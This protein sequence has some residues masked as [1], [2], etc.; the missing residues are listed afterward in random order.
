MAGL[1]QEQTEQIR[2]MSEWVRKK[3]AAEGTGHDW[4]HIERVR[5]ISL[6]IAKEEGADLFVTEA[7]TLL[8]DMIDVKLDD[9]HRVPLDELKRRLSEDWKVDPGTI[10]G[11][12]AI[13]TRM[14][15]RDREKYKDERLSKE[16][17]AVQDADRLDAIGAVGIARALMYAGAKGHLLY[18]SANAP[19]AVGHFY[20]KLLLLKDL[21]NTKTGRMLAEK[22]HQLML[23][24]L[25]ELE[26]ECAFSGE[27]RLDR[28]GPGVM[29]E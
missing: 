8:H 4:L 22:R 29:V 9:E 27:S 23:E 20:E 17:M 19:T 5:N 2:L 16:G 14:S 1:N 24:F 11:I 7:S 28:S 13:I 25:G 3:L 21:M 12:L 15:F 26:N 10:D 18:G 6:Q